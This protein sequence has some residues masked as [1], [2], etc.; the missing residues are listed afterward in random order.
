MI[1]DKI[2]EEIAELKRQEEK[3][4]IKRQALEAKLFEIAA[5]KIRKEKQAARD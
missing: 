1:E 5:T 4:R 2:K 3:I